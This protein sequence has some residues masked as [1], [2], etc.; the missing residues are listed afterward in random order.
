MLFPDKL[1]FLMELTSTSNKQLAEAL[2][3]DPSLISRFR[4]GTRSIPQKS[5]YFESMSNYF[6]N[7]CSAD[8][9]LKALSETIGNYHLDTNPDTAITAAVIA[10]WLSSNETGYQTQANTLLRTFNQLK[11]TD[12][13]NLCCLPASTSSPKALQKE[14]ELFACHGVEGRRKAGLLF[15]QY[16]LSANNIGEIKLLNEGNTDWIWS[17]KDFALEA[18]NDITQLINR[19]GTITRIVPRLDN[20]S[21]T[22][23]AVTRWLPLHTTGRVKSFYYPH[24]R[25]NVFSRTL[26]VAPG[27]A[28]LFST[29]VGYKKVSDITFLTT[30]PATIAALNQEFEDFLTLCTPAAVIYNQK[31][32]PL[33]I[34]KS[35]MDFLECR[36]SAITILRELSYVTIPPEVLDSLSKRFEIDRLRG[37]HASCYAQF[38][39]RLR[40]SSYTDVFSLASFENIIAGNAKYTAHGISNNK[41]LYYTPTEYQMHLA[42]IIK[43]LNQYPNYN[44]ILIEKSE[45]D[46]DI[47]INERYHVML[48]RE[49]PSLAICNIEY[50]EMVSAMWEY[51]ISKTRT[52]C[53]ANIN[54]LQV[55]SQI[56]DLMCQIDDYLRI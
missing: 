9:Q 49:K 36:S 50:P 37:F 45:I 30:D 3:V 20:L 53:S 46:C 43:L 6:A 8:Y 48:V 55:I 22:Y 7:K 52:G 10:V 2:N 21:M 47:Y 28:A 29:A 44:V 16:A 54:R 42:N 32:Y 33:Q 56:S 26:Y 31:N 18:S 5:E 35:I 11:F 14:G 1:I 17:N 38:Q 27:A 51:A 19:G 4:R 24:I 15:L 34:R 12:I 41:E 40:C 13:D 25:D 39:N 23:D